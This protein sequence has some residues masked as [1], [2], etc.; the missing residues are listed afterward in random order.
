MMPRGTSEGESADPM[1]RNGTFQ[2]GEL[3]YQGEARCPG[4]QGM[5]K[6][7]HWEDLEMHGTQVPKGQTALGCPSH[8]ICTVGHTTP[9]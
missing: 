9:H 3:V 7:N 2:V 6:K 1:K 5:V 4:G 8:H